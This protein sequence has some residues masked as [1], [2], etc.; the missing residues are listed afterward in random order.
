M[1]NLIFNYLAI[2][3]IAISCTSKVEVKPPLAKKFQKNSPFTAIP[4]LIIITG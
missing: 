1:K 2:V 4:G 3:L